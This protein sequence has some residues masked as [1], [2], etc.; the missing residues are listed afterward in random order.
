MS[1]VTS[2]IYRKIFHDLVQTLKEDPN[3]RKNFSV[4][5][6]QFIEQVIL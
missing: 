4:E 5:Q 3:L 2:E 1:K 6:V